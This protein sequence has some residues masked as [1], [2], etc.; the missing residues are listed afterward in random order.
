MSSGRLNQARVITPSSPGKW[1]APPAGASLP[2]VIIASVRGY[3]A[4]GRIYVGQ[5][6]GDAFN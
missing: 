3:S 5:V 2:H 6:K 4:S 1:E